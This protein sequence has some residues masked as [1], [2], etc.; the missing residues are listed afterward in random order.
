MADKK[1]TFEFESAWKKLGKRNFKKIMAFAEDYKVFLDSAKTERE[2]VSVMTETI[3]ADGFKELED[4]KALKAGDK[5][6]KVIKNKGLVAAIM[7][8]KPVTDG[9][10]IL[11]AHIDSPR[12]DLK[13][14]P[15]YESDSLALLKTHYYGGIKKHQFTTIPLSMHGIIYNEKGEKLTISIGEDEGDPVFTITEILVHLS[16]Q[17]MQRK[18]AQMVKGEEMNVLFAGMPIDD[19]DEK[20]KVKAAALKLIYD[21]YGISEKDFVTAELEMVPAFKASDVGIDR[22]FV[23]G[24]GQ[25]DRVCAY[26]ELRALLSV[27]DPEFTAV[28]CFTDKEETGSGSS[29]GATSR[30]YE[31]VLAELLYKSVKGATDMDFRKALENT[32]MLSSDVTS[33]YEPNFKGEAFDKLNCT[34]AGSGVGILKYTGARGKYSCNDASGEFFHEVVSVFDKDKV[35]WQT[36]ELGAIDVGGGG[37][38]AMYMAQMGL[39]VIDCGVPVLSMHSPFEVTSK[40]DIYSAYLGFLA[41]IQ[42]CGR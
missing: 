1:L 15:L 4:V 28:A 11:G 33:A 29:T 32:R 14:M 3:K 21:K 18:P 23:G 34:Y 9:M 30:L 38:I 42:K 39:E 25:D 6:Y 24:Y 22:S 12:T 27:K 2:C 37:T 41:F 26:T 31:N 10:N 19:E 16:D 7:G 17:Q 20:N 13:P 5:V 40:A 35:P 36:G 8:K